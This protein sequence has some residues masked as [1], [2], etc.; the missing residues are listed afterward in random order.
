MSIPDMINGS[1]EAFAG[2]MIGLHCRRL[3]R[4]KLVRG[5]SIVATAFFTTWG[6]WNIF[7]YAAIAQWASW[8][9]GFLVVSANCVWIFLMLY[10]KRQERRLLHGGALA[11]FNYFKR[12]GNVCE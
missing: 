7:Y 5:V 3:Y 4:D 11:K 6:F 2:V 10:Y 8:V 9:A 1:F 12:S